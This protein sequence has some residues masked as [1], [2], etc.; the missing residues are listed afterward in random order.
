MP[1]DFHDIA[2]APKKALNLVDHT[3]K[4]QVL[5]QFLDSTGPLVEAGRIDAISTGSLAKL[6]GMFSTG[7]APWCAH[8]F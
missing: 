6:H 8:Y 2:N 1:I 5:K 3:E 4:R 7:S